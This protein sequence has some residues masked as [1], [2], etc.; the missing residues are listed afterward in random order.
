MAHTGGR[1][2]QGGYKVCCGGYKGCSGMLWKVQG[3][4]IWCG[5][6]RVCYWILAEE[7]TGVQ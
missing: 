7:G 4:E 6:Y 5:R 2:S 3:T 1:V